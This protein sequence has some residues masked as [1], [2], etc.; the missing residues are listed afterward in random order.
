MAKSKPKMPMP[1]SERAKQFSPFSPLK[2]LEAA[3][4]EKERLREPRREVSE[5]QA[6]EID[7]ILGSLAMGDTLTAVYY[8]ADREEYVQLTGILNKIDKFERFLL[9][10]AEK[11][12]FDDLFALYPA[13]VQR[14][15]FL[16][17][18]EA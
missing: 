2:G 16:H 11:I 6:L 8:Q 13:D 5:D 7:R 17:D 14:E 15:A 4:A 12:A 18:T 10:G 9:L 1:I 3:L